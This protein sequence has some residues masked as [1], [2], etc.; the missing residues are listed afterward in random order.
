MEVREAVLAVL[1][2]EGAPLHWTVIQ[3][4]ALR[5][6]YVDPFV[7]KDVRKQVLRALADAARAGEVVKAGT[8]LYTL[9]A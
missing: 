2:E 3:D 1:R 9:P 7:T 8:G 6:G 5:R 4:L